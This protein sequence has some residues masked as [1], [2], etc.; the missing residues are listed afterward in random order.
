MD[1]SNRSQSRRFLGYLY[2]LAG[3]TLVAVI[4]VSWSLQHLSIAPNGRLA[5]AMIPVALWSGA[6]VVLVLT[7]RSL[8][9]LQRRIQLEALAIAFPA[10]MMLGMTVEYL[11]KAGYAAEVGVGDVW[12]FMFLLYVPALV[13]AHARYR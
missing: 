12:P 13:Y 7:F 4:A 10:A 2:L 5:L 1:A 8:D 6:I 9:E 11:Q 3:L